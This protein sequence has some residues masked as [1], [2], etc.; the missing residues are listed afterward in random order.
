MEMQLATIAGPV[1]FLEQKKGITPFLKWPGGKRWFVAS[2]A[3]LLPTTF[4][5][6]V[7]PFLGGGSVFFHLRPMESLLSDVN[8][9]LIGTYQAIRD[10]YL[11]L[12][13]LLAAHQ[14][15]HGHDYYYTVRES[16]PRVE[17]SKAARLIYLNRTC[18][19]GIYR[20]NLDGRFNVPKGTKSSVLLEKDDFEGAAALLKTADLRVSDFEPVIDDAGAGDL[21]FADPPY[22]VRHNVNGF[23]KYNEHLFSWDD[24]IRLA[25]ALTR[26]RAR[27]A[28]I[29]S[30]NANHDSI[31]RLYRDRGFSLTAIS[32]Y[33][34]ISAK[35][36]NRKQFEELVIRAV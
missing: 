29:V 9:E 20:V 15:K 27:G 6:Y 4:K 18:F 25:N 16:R 35:A 24:Q 2:H 17:A 32:R 34:S 30:T 13:K 36:T 14:T 1:N 8:A 7:E 31:R 21:V 3:D 33:S 5:R 12:E 26:A 11:I 10:S 19:N 28:K 23:V 22:T